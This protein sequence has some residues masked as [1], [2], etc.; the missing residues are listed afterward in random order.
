MSVWMN[1]R[2]LS[3][4]IKLMR[5]EWK[6][7]LA[8]KEISFQIFIYKSHWICIQTHTFIHK[9]FPIVGIIFVY[10][11]FISLRINELDEI[12]NNSKNTY[13]HWLKY[14]RRVLFRSIRSIW[15]EVYKKLFISY[16][17]NKYLEI[18]LV[19]YWSGNHFDFI[20]FKL[21][22]KITDTI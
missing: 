8:M 15:T 17:L 14:L 10:K 6:Y 12:W 16:F 4:N 18:I 20:S 2:L 22:S 1:E 19:Y 5:D 9:Y 13:F 11:V 7:F 21:T 3:L